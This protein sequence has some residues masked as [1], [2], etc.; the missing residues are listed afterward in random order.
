MIN[1][2]LSQKINNHFTLS[3]ARL[4]CVVQIIISLIKVSSVNISLLAIISS[5]EAKFSSIYRQ[6]QRFFSEFAFA[7]NQFAQFI[8]RFFGLEN[9]N[10][11][12]ALDRTNWA[13]GKAQINIL[14]LAIIIKGTAIPLFWLFLDK[15][16]IQIL[17]KEFN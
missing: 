5:G 2:P 17:T 6:L 9:E 4:N 16:V 14:N 1:H 13:Y 7:S 3:T 15:K 8:V 11:F 12:L 10:W